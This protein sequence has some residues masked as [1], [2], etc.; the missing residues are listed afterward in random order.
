[1]TAAPSVG[2]EA[3]LEPSVYTNEVQSHAVALGSGWYTRSARWGIGY[4]RT[5]RS[6]VFHSR[7]LRRG[8]SML[9][10]D[11]NGI[12]LVWGGEYRR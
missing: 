6:F 10:W 2:W 9:G 11:G 1:M 7:C 5:C 12:G 8:G 4:V 3:F